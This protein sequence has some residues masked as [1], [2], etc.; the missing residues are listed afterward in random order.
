MIF[1]SYFLLHPLLSVTSTLH[2]CLNLNY[3]NSFTNGLFLSTYITCIH[4][5]VSKV[6]SE[7]CLQNPREITHSPIQNPSMAS[8]LPLLLQ[9]PRSSMSWALTMSLASRLP[10]SLFAHSAPGSWTS[11]SQ[12]SLNIPSLKDPRVFATAWNTSSIYPQ[13]SPLVLQVYAQMTPIKDLFYP[14]HIKCP[15]PYIIIFAFPL[16]VFSSE[17]FLVSL[18]LHV[19]LLSLSH[20]KNVSSEDQGPLLG[21]CDSEAGNSVMRWSLRRGSTY[22]LAS[23][24]STQGSQRKEWVLQIAEINLFFSLGN[25]KK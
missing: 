20:Y 5:T 23:C 3:F 12:F 18:I 4:P 21:E 22:T 14:P 9:P 6:Y 11:P 15:T 1:G 7:W 8:H 13:I 24:G 10:L 16:R 2:L 19:C 17:H 25:A